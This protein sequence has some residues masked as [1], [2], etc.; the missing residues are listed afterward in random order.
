VARGGIYGHAAMLLMMEGALAD[1]VLSTPATMHWKAGNIA[2]MRGETVDPSYSRRKAKAGGIAGRRGGAVDLPHV[3]ATDW[4]D[5]AASVLLWFL[6]GYGEI[7]PQLL[8]GAGEVSLKF[9][10]VVKDGKKDDEK[11]RV[12]KSVERGFQVFRSYGSVEAPVGELW[13]GDVAYFKVREEELRR[14]VEEAKRTAPNLSGI[15]KIW[16]ALEWF[17]TDM[18]FIGGQIEGGTARLWQLRW[19]LALF[20]EGRVSGGRSNVTEEGLRPFVIM[21]W[22]REDLDRIIAEES[23]ELEPLLAPSLNKEAVL[24]RPKDPPSRAGGSW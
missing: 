9:R 7:D 24:E 10:L 4:G 14:L 11:K 2:K 8:S 5:R 18:S 1:I 17:A 20:G 19:Y 13:I 16:Q 12:K 6:I 22:R 3:E 21:R 23:K 15:R